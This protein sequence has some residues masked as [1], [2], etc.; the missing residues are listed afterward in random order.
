MSELFNKVKLFA[1]RVDDEFLRGTLTGDE[2]TKKRAHW[3]K[4]YYKLLEE[5]ARFKGAYPLPCFYHDTNK[6][7]L[8]LK[9]EDGERRGYLW[10]G[11]NCK[12]NAHVYLN[13][14][15]IEEYHHLPIIDLDKDATAKILVQ[16]I[17]EFNGR[18]VK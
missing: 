1:D 12:I 9:T 18:E 5:D 10:D 4:G 16:I 14:S 11:I 3:F 15:D 2:L 17:D 7:L 8:I 6:K 13:P